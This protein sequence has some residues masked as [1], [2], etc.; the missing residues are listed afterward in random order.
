MK[1]FYYILWLA[2]ARYC[3]DVGVGKSY[4]HNAKPKL[5]ILEYP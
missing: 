3:I 2:S 1:T 5:D 4:P